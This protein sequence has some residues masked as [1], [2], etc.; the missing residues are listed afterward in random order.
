MRFVNAEELEA[1]LPD[2][3]ASPRD[4]GAVVMIVRRPDT[5]KREVVESGELDAVEGLAALPYK[6]YNF[7]ERAPGP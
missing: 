7:S 3:L 4:E 6:P 5:N 2:I 1:G